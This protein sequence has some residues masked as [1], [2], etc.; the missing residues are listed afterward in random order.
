MENRNGNVQTFIL[1]SGITI[2]VE[3]KVYEHSSNKLSTVCN[4][5][6]WR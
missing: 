6:G 4:A 2:S 5:V 1:S 3:I